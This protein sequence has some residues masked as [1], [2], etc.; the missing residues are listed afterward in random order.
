MIFPVETVATYRS[1]AL[2]SQSFA[3]FLMNCMVSIWKLT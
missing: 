1:D 3:K 2:S